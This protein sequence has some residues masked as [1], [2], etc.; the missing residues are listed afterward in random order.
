MVRQ[1]LFVWWWARGIDL[2][3]DTLVPLATTGLLMYGGYQVLQGQITLGDLTM[4][5]VYLTMLLGPIAALANSATLFQN[6][7][8]GLDR[9]LTLLDEPLEAGRQEAGS[10]IN[11][12]EVIIL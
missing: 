6:N 5:L 11:N 4:F 9:I 8:A 1:S 7:L 10:H 3:W 12:H 2:I